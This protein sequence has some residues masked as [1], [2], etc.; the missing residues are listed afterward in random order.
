VMGAGALTVTVRCAVLVWPTLSV[1][2][3]VTV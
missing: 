2:V 1:T 3:S